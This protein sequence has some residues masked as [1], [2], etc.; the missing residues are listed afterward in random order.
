M[1][2]KIV[3]GKL[4]L[5]EGIRTDL[6]LYVEGDKIA[7][8][9]PLDLPY[10]RQI[11]ADGCYVS[12]GFI[13]VHVH[14]GGGYDFMD[15]DTESIVRAADFHL[16]F[17]TTTIFPTALAASHEALVT[18]LQNLRQVRRSKATK[19]MV[20]GAHI[21]GPYFS[22]RQAGAQNPAYIRHPDPTEYLPLLEEYGEDIRRWSFAPEL[23]GSEAFCCALLA[24]G[25]SPSIA[26]SDAVYDDVKRVYDAGCRTVTHLYSGMST[27][28]RDCGY[29]RLGVVE[30]AYLLEDMAVEV[31]ADGKHLPP[32]LLR[33]ILLSKSYERVCLVTDAMR[34]AGT[35][36]TET[37]LGP[38]DEAVP[39]IV[40]DGVA[41][42]PDRTAFA[43]SVATADRLVRTMVKQAGVPVE[44]AVAMMTAVPATLFGLHKKGRLCVGNDADILLFDENIGIKKVI[45]GGIDYG[46]SDL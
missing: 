34:A 7:Y 19:G 17:G 28:T 42:L 2:T 5:P 39:C 24:N 25:V 14:G 26:H 45:A 10:E 23:P 22:L 31:I 18:F 44:R 46:N 37:F 20:A 4:L 33:L 30:S 41:K 35:R 16:Q 11:D 29:R 3:N 15:G 36:Q 13:D 8:I 32:E 43:G 38:R 27:I 21:E 12:P 1:T 40:E 6:S 9:T